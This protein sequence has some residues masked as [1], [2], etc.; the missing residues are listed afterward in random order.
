VT[1]ARTVSWPGSVKWPDSEVPDLS[2]DAS[3]TD[4]INFVYDGT[5]YFG[6]YDLGYNKTEIGFNSAGNCGGDVGSCSFSNS[7]G[8][9]M[10]ITDIGDTGAGTTPSCSYNGVSATELDSVQEPSDRWLYIFYLTNPATGS[11]TISCTG[12]SFNEISAV[13]YSGANTT[14]Q[15][16]THSV[17]GPVGSDVSYSAT[18]TVDNA[19]AVAWAYGGGTIT[20]GANTTFRGTVLDG[21]SF[22]DNDGPIQPAGSVSL[23]YNFSNSTTHEGFVVTIKPE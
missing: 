20:A 1:G 3:S 7:A 16:D 23:N 14:S 9:L 21:S 12:P 5:S 13:T 6:S 2:T 18:S 15:P 11:H 17:Q 19:W 4:V 8:D 10:L 22:A